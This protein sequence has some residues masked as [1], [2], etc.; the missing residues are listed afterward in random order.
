M[1]SILKQNI[2]TN[3]YLYYVIGIF[4]Y[5]MYSVH[6]YKQGINYWFTILTFQIMFLLNE[7]HGQTFAISKLIPSS[8]MLLYQIRPKIKFKYE[9]YISIS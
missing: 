2:G 4:F 5:S 9:N 7:Q 1:F 3:K 6:V 8:P